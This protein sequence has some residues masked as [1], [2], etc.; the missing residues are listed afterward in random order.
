MHLH[1]GQELFLSWFQS[2][3]KG[4]G[5]SCNRFEC[6]LN[7]TCML[8]NDKFSLRKCYFKPKYLNLIDSDCD[9]DESCPWFFIATVLATGPEFAWP[10][11]GLASLLLAICRVGLAARNFGN[12]RVVLCTWETIIASS[13]LQLPWDGYVIFGFF[14]CILYNIITIQYNLI[15]VNLGGP[16]VFYNLYFFCTD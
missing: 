1:L 13:G 14:V 9:V 12:G 6:Q 16:F 2:G 15:F 11:V 8:L 5:A 3:R 7:N 10:N 4:S